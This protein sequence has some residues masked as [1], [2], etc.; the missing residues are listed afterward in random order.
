[1]ARRQRG[2]TGGLAEFL[3]LPAQEIK[4]H[5]DRF[6]KEI[7]RQWDPLDPRG[8]S[9][10]ERVVR[11]PAPFATAALTTRARHTRARRGCVDR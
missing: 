8:P 1:M 3:A 10:P 5:Q 9:E 2:G 7:A 11:A 4:Q 6:H